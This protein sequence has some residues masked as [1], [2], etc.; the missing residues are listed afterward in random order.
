MPRQPAQRLIDFERSMRGP[1]RRALYAMVGQPLESLLA[2]N[3]INAAYD[4]I[5]ATQTDDN[6]FIKAMMALGISYEVA[7]EDL[8]RIPTTGPVVAVANHP[9]GAMEGIALGAILLS[10][11]SDARLLANYLLGQMAGIRPWLFEVDPFAGAES[12]KNNLRA[13]R[14]TIKWLKEGHCIG[15]FPSGTVSHLQLRRRQVTDPTW[16]P[17]TARLIRASEATA[18]P[19]F[20]EGK[21]SAFFQI[22]GLVHPLLR[23]A[24]LPRE[25]KKKRN[26]A[27]KVRIG[28]PIPFRRLADFETDEAMTDFLRLNTY[29][30][31][32]RAPNPPRRIFPKPFL[33]QPVAF[34]TGKKNQ[35]QEELAPPVAPEDLE[36]EVQS[37]PP[38]SV[39]VNGEQFR[40]H[41]ARANQIPNLLLEIGRLREKTFREVREGTG[42]SRD[43]DR[44]DQYYVHLFMWDAGARAIVGAYRIGLTDEIM[45]QHGKAG[46]YTSTLF[47]YKDEFPE[48]L[49]PAMELGRSFI[50]SEY[51]KKQASLALL[52]RGIGQFVV[53]YPRYSRL[54]GP[55][56]INPEYNAISKDLIVQFLR[57]NNFDRKLASLVR[58]KRPPRRQKLRGAEKEALL[59]S[60]RDIDDVSALVSE[61]EVDKKGVPVLLRH[62]LKMNGQLISF[63]IDPD[64]GQCLDGLIVVDLLKSDAKLLKAYLGPDGVK[65]FYAFHGRKPD[66]TPAPQSEPKPVAAGTPDR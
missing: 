66:G 24:L 52:W 48:T 9:Y 55:V 36:R 26:H 34:L 43:L 45:A 1:V 65:A 8:A 63:N 58:A 47:K 54:F 23:T 11:R 40:V 21:N 15:T 57:K 29:L 30:L 51:Q 28:N 39:L 33:T 42:M 32:D 7:D 4:R 44:F 64:F 62:Y 35:P 25:L 50:A 41:V 17:N 49:D 38:E 3:Y 14:D 37:L 31:R 18:V 46:L 10:V 16:N 59:S 53:R 5:L 6:F 61:I 60:V 13:M 27:L 22:A 12:A 20:F 2:V 19:I 56:S